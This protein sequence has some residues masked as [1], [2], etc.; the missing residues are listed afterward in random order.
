MS[1]KII[2]GGKCLVGLNFLIKKMQVV[3]VTWYRYH[4]KREFETG[5]VIWAT[6]T[7]V[8]SSDR[9]IRA[10]FVSVDNPFSTCQS[11]ISKLKISTPTFPHQSYQQSK[12]KTLETTFKTFPRGRLRF[13]FHCGCNVCFGQSRDQSFSSSDFQGK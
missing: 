7:P 12:K 6:L 10:A 4:R 11:N 9:S 2:F 1:L 3:R 13:C 5:V 8:R